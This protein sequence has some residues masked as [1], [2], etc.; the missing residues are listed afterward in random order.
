M[1]PAASICVGQILKPTEAG[2][3]N[4]FTVSHNEKL[5]ARQFKDWLSQGL[6][7]VRKHPY[8]F[9]PL[10]YHPRHI[11]D[12]VFGI[13]PLNW[14]QVEISHSSLLEMAQLNVSYS[15]ALNEFTGS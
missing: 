11:H 14:Q 13:I 1:I 12:S 4:K 5:E 9:Y 15:S 10:Y 3:K 6:D 2:F 7:I 8:S